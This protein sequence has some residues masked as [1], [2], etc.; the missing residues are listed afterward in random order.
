MVRR[1]RGGASHLAGVGPVTAASRHRTSGD[2]NPNLHTQ[3]L[4]CNM[5]RRPDGRWTALHAPELWYHGRTAGFV[6]QSVLRHEL[7]SQLDIRFEPVRRGVAEVVG[8]P[9]PVRSLFSQRREAIEESM[10]AHG[11]RSAVAPRSPRSTPVR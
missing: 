1:G 6:Y 4:T 5:S 11:T 10:A 9:E 3:L 7:A 2:P 8:I